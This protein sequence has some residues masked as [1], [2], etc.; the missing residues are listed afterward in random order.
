MVGTPTTTGEVDSDGQSGI[1]HVMVV[2]SYDATAHER[3]PQTST[4]GEPPPL[5]KPVPVRVSVA[6]LAKVV[7]DAAVSVGVAAA[8]KEKLQGRSEPDVDS[9]AGRR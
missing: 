9:D 2:A 7:A 6:F 1:V 4:V 5:A 3:P 8:S